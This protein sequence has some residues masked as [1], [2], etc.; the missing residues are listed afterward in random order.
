MIEPCIIGDAATLSFRTAETATFDAAKM[1]P[2]S[3]RPMLVRDICIGVRVPTSGASMQNPGL[4]HNIKIEAGRFTVTQGFI[5][6]WLLAPVFDKK[7]DNGARTSSAH[8]L[9]ALA[10]DAWHMKW[11]LPK[12]MYLPPNTQLKVSIQRDDLYDTL[13]GPS[14]TWNMGSTQIVNVSARGLLLDKQ[15]ATSEVPFVSAFVPGTG[16][17]Q[18][19]EQDLCNVLDK[20]LTLHRL[21]GRIAWKTFPFLGFGTINPYWVNG[22]EDAIGFRGDEN[23]GDPLQAVP[24]AFGVRLRD[25]LGVALTSGITSEYVPFWTVF[26]PGSNAWNMQRVLQANEHISATLSAAVTAY[27]RPM[28]SMVGY[29]TERI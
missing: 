11:I 22:M 13:V 8:A 15:Q 25:S 12:P 6:T 21:I 9:G 10:Q 7:Q 26:P 5:P 16:Q 29:R 23:T 17:L 20:P 28:I 14:G 3:N 19:A 24:R 1:T 18:S 27:K 4:G 2:P